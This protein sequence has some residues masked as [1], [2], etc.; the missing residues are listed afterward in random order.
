[1]LTLEALNSSLPAVSDAG[2]LKLLHLTFRGLMFGVHALPFIGAP[3]V[4][5]LWLQD[6]SIASM[7]VW[8]GGGVLLNFWGFHLKRKFLVD[9]ESLP[10]KENLCRWIPAIHRLAIAYGIGVSLLA[11]ITIG[12]VSDGFMYLLLTAQAAVVA[13]NASHLSPE[14]GTFNRFFFVACII[15]LVTIPW[16][17]EDEWIATI[18]LAAIFVIAIRHQAKN[19]HSL[20]V[21]FVQLEDHSKQLA[22]H[23]RAAKEDAEFLLNEKNQFLTTVSH[24]LRQPIH[25]MGFLI[26]S[27][28]QRNC[29]ASLTS[30]LIDLKKSVRTATQMFNALLDL[31]RIENG[32]IQARQEPV[33]LNDLV[34]EVSVTFKQEAQSRNLVLRTHYYSKGAAMVV[35]DPLLLQQSLI[36]LLHNSLRYTQQGG[37]LIGVRKRKNQW[38]LEVVDTGIGISTSDGER[39]YTPFFR[40]QH[41]WNIDQAG[42]G[43]GLAV[44]ARC[45]K[46]MQAEYGFLSSE[47]KGSRFWLRLQATHENYPSTQSQAHNYSSSTVMQLCGE[48][49]IIDDDPQVLSAWS[50]LMLAWGINSRC[51]SSATEVLKIIDSGFSPRAILC[52]QRLR[53]GES[54]LE[55]LKMLFVRFPEASGAMVS[56]EYSSDELR[57]AEEE[58]YLVLQKPLEPAQ[59]YSLLSQWLT[60]SG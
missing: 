18:F 28:V 42:L 48:C 36:N 12:Q 4:I 14:M 17:F 22:D 31:S 2:R 57:Q 10:I 50:S 11:P 35:A 59:L 40:K 33:N 5:W 15:I 44:V 46:L 9:V 3:F 20:F 58:G 43:L 54:G 13:G 23:Y 39:V 29:D 24:D 34:E 51:A 27:I 38:Q 7:L 1:M 6:Q 53:S 21:Q 60:V 41:A 25:A 37:I 56:G 30:A 32:V 26:E 52:D 47:G 8:Y 49:L 16:G 45:A 19:S 55:I